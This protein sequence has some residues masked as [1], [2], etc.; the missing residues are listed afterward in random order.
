MHF[1]ALWLFI[2]EHQVLN[3]HDYFF[4]SLVLYSSLVLVSL[5]QISPGKSQLVWSFTLIFFFLSPWK[6]IS[7]MQDCKD[8][9]SQ[10]RA[11]KP[12]TGGIQV[13]RNL[14]RAR[15]QEYSKIKQAVEIIKKKNSKFW[16][17]SSN[18]L[19][20][21]FNMVDQIEAKNLLFFIHH[22]FIPLQVRGQA[23]C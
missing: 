21:K 10:V 15:T 20:Y 22:S 23:Q 8:S 2:L 16:F 12:K 3:Q 9:S 11:C 4:L 1:L 6:V 5:S 13:N 17:M 19:W 18:M 14:E 7:T